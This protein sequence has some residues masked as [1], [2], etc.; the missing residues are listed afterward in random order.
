MSVEFELSPSKEIV[1]IP[2]PMFRDRLTVVDKVYHQPKTGEAFC[3]ETT[4]ERWLDHE[5][6]VY[7]RKMK[8]GKDWQLLKFGW[9]TDEAKPIGMLVI[10]NDEG[11]YRQTLPTD[12]EKAETAEK[13]L[14]VGVVIIAPPVIPDEDEFVRVFLVPPGM[15]NRVIP[16][17]TPLYVRCLGGECSYT[18]FAFPK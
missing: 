14:E 16:A 10:R 3:C 2:K 7:S 13:V 15:S 9:F 12:E 18:V 11:Q 6:S 4:F 17:D 8:V 1:A 5:E